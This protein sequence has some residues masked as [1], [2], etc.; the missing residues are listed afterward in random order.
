MV[1]PAPKIDERTAADIAKQV[2]DLLVMYTQG[3]WKEFEIDPVTGDRKPKGISAALIGVFARFAEII[4]QRLNQVPDKNLLAFLNLLGASRL[5]PQPARVPLTFFLTAGSTV[6]ALVT[7]GTQ[8][9]A[10][11]AQGQ[12]EPVIFETERELVVTSAQLASIFVRDPEQGT[13]SDRSTWLTPNNSTPGFVFRGDRPIEHSLYLACDDLFTLAVPKTVTL[14][15]QSPEVGKLAQLPLIWS[16]WDGKNWQPLSVTSSTPTE[17]QWQ[18]SIANCPVPVK[19]S[20]DGVAASWIKVQL[21]QPLPSGST[22]LPSIQS[23]NASVRVQRQDLLPDLAFNNSLPLDLTKDFYPFGETPRL[24]NTLYF[25]SQEVFSKAATTVTVN[26]ILNET[27]PVNT[28]GGVDLAWEAWDGSIW[29]P[30]TVSSGSPSPAKFTQSGSVTFTLPS[31]MGSREENGKTNYWIRVRIIGGNY[32]LGNVSSQ[33]ATFT[34]LTQTSQ[35]TA[36]QERLTVNSVRGFMPDDRIQIAAGSNTQEN[37]V[38]DS[39]DT[40]SNTLTLTTALQ[41]THPVGTG[42]WLVNNAALFP[43]LVKSLKLSYTYEVTNQPL[44][45]CKKYNEFTYENCLNLAFSPF[46]APKESK[47]TLYFGFTLP[48]NR[49]NFSNRPFS[50]FV[51]LADLKYGEKFVPLDPVHSRQVGA[52]G[53]TVKHQLWVTNDT[54]HSV[55]WM[56]IVLDNTWIT[57]APSSITVDGYETK[58]LE[59]EITIP[60]SLNQQP[61]DRAFLRLTSPDQPDV[62]YSTILETFVGQE[63]PSTKQIHLSWEYWNGQDWSKFSV[64]DGTENFTRSG[65]IQFLLPTDFQPKAS[66]FSTKF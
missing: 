37:K 64:D 18:I 30:L 25:A 27:V 4:I 38:I 8:V 40:K 55:T 29:Q 1:K 36:N 48:Q 19:R 5:P 54:P 50:L 34:T 49:S 14:T 12:S 11:P 66:L 43:P 53:K 20:L 28:E 3:E 47:P 58:S 60:G 15:I 21:N 39:V 46:Q 16:Y 7:N 23:I 51:R 42:V 44:S 52:T 2:Q 62:I 10:P 9:A 45:A 31:Q 65:L 32:G 41:N 63:Q 33:L 35:N 17:Q 6:D 57:N 22:P 13:W 24:S 59:V 26:I 56:V 61:S